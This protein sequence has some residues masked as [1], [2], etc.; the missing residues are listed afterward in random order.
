MT[1]TEQLRADIDSG[2]TGDTVATI[3]TAAAPLGTDDEAAGTPPTARAI[4]LARSHEVK[5]AHDRGD[6]RKAS[7]ALVYTAVLAVIATLLVGV[8][9]FVVPRLASGAKR[10]RPNET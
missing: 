5:Y 6:Q 1:T 3:D 2:R 8:L 10:A 7:A 9:F 4:A